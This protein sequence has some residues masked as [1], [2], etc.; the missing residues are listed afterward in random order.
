[1]IALLTACLFEILVRGLNCHDQ[2]KRA[3]KLCSATRLKQCETAN[4]SI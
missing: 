3:Q 2:Q 1:M 4:L